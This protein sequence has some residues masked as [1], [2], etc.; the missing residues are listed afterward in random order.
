MQSAGSYV[1]I[2]SSPPPGSVGAVAAV[3]DGDTGGVIRTGTAWPW[4]TTGNRPPMWDR[5]APTS[6]ERSA[7][8]VPR[9]VVDRASAV[10]DRFRTV[11]VR[12]GK[13]DGAA[14]TARLSTLR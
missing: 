9:P 3:C 12:A 2:S 1:L 11:R 13:S 14:G 7:E 8:D 10:R 6:R 5:R 4:G